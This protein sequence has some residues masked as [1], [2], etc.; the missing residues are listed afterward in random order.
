[1]KAY[2]RNISGID[3]A[4][5]AMYF[6]KRTWNIDLDVSVRQ[7]VRTLSRADGSIRVPSADVDPVWLV[8]MYA[9][10]EESLN[11]LVKYGVG[12][13]M[14]AAIDE[15][16]ETLL[17]FI[18]LSIVIEDLHRGAMDDLDS[19]AMRM[20]NRIVRSS[21]RIAPS[22]KVSFNPNELSDWY[23]D[24]AITFASVIHKLLEE[25]KL[26]SLFDDGTL[27]RT[28]EVNG[29][30]FVFTEYGYI[31]EKYLDDQ[32]V[33]RGLFPLGM[34]SSCIF[35]VSF[36]DM[37]HIYKR[38]NAFTHAAPELK[39]AIESLADQIDDDIP[40]L[41]KYIRCDHCDFD[42]VTHISKI[43]KIGEFINDD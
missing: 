15:G 33:K 20:N 13:G 17:R 25:D 12:N 21:S 43:H 28:I 38:R 24:K 32:D 35:R 14:L 30:K 3:D 36:H 10:F 31:N 1:M 37:R 29:N 11:K 41:G 2:L 22:D 19:H 16:H 4:I 42:R 23:S 9:K 27:S 18:D 39:L 34:K 26:D 8:E 40:I 5:L 6:S 7:T